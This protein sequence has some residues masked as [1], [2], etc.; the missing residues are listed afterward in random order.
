MPKRTRPTHK[1][2]RSSQ[3][4]FSHSITPG[5]TAPAFFNTTR[6]GNE[7]NDIDIKKLLDDCPIGGSVELPCGKLVYRASETS[8]VPLD[9]FGFWPDELED[10]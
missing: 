6:K 5:P 1:R 3:N 8:Y 10:E 4:T 9:G 7:M 2:N